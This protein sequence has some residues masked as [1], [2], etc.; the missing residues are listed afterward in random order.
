MSKNDIVNKIAKER[1]VE[2]IASHYKTFAREDLCQYIYLYLLEKVDDDRL[3]ELYNTNKLKQY[4]AG[5]V[6]RQ[7]LS[8]K[9]E[10]VKTYSQIGCSIENL[11]ELD[12]PYA[13]KLM[14]RD[15]NQ[16]QLEDNTDAFLETLTPM[17]R[18]M[19]WAQIQ[20]TAERREDIDI[21]CQKYGITYRQY[22]NI[23]PSVMHKWYIKYGKER[24]KKNYPA[25]Q[26]RNSRKVKVLDKKDNLLWVSDNVEDAYNKVLKHTYITKD[27]IYK[28]LN[29]KRQSA[30]GYKFLYIN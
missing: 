14:Y 10:Y 27:M 1:W 28:V 17:E 6:H 4:I 30:K 24:P 20:P 11:T 23:L 2:K 16:H 15:D 3:I 9:S 18:S 29:G 13:E 12:K 8:K 26:I 7:I 5:M 19:S 21:I 22:Q 25:H